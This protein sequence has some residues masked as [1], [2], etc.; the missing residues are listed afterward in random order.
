VQ[1]AVWAEPLQV[2]PV[3]V[4]A[5]KVSPAGMVS[6]T[7]IVPLVA[8]V[9]LLLTAIVY[10]PVAPIVKFPVCD[11]AIASA[12]LRTVVGFVAVGVLPAPPPE[13][14]AEFVTVAGAFAATLTVSAIGFAPAATATTA[15]VVQVT[16]A[17]AFVHVQPVPDAALKVR[18]VGSVSV[19]VI[20]PAVARLP[21][22]LTESVYVPVEPAVKLPLCDFASASTGAPA[23]VVGSVAVGVLAAPPPLAPAVLVSDPGAVVPGIVTPR[24]IDANAPEAATAAVL[25][26]VMTCPAALHVQP[27]PVADAYVIPAGSVSVTVVVPKV[28]ALPVLV[29]AIV[30]VPAPPIGKLPVCDFAIA[31]CG[32]AIVVGSV[33]VGELFAPPPEAVALLVRLPGAV[34]VGTLTVSVIAGNAADA[35]IA[36]ELVHVTTCAAALHDQPLPVA[37]AYVSPAG[38]VSVTVVVPNVVALP[39]LLAVTVYV[40][41]CPTT[42][43]PTC[44]FAS[45]STGIVTVVAS[46]ALPVLGAPPPEDEAVLVTLGT[47]DAATATT[48]TIGCPMLEALMTVELLQVTVGAAL[49]HV[50]PVPVA[51]TK[52]RPAGKVSTTV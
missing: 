15:L 34:D 18:P 12:G 48:S 1:V 46:L 20:V 32:W 19:T 29:T 39:V 49:V 42:N 38:R 6:V 43:D 9:P 14:V 31:S 52:V 40:P 37:V 24:V 16:T 5:L 28:V 13:A 41:F 44:D 33:A 50:Q 36:A 2:Q 47:A 35:A 3:P 10:V 45:A 22:L 17:P 30:Y 26:Q 25:V 21:V 11:F 8:A 23:I 4:A 51:L 27:V 7:V